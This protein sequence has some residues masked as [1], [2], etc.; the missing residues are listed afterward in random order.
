MYFVPFSCLAD[1]KFKSLIV[2]A[3]TTFWPWYLN[4]E[5]TPWAC[6]PRA[7]MFPR[8]RNTVYQYWQSAEPDSEY[9]WYRGNIFALGNKP[10]AFFTIFR[11]VGAAL[12]R[13]QQNQRSAILPLYQPIHSSEIYLFG[14]RFRSLVDLSVWKS[15]KSVQKN[16]KLAALRQWD[17]SEQRRFPGTKIYTTPAN[18]HQTNKFLSVPIH[19]HK[20]GLPKYETNIRQQ[21]HSQSL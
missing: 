7:K 14:V 17:F 5:K 2:Q 16:L 12:Q 6:L 11:I 18:A 9:R 3:R 20:G 19:I 8:Y 10:R 21:T 13:S 15:A 4:I 1:P